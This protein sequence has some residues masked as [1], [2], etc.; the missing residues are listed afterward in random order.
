MTSKNLRENDCCFVDRTCILQLYSQ[1]H[2]CQHIPLSWHH[3]EDAIVMGIPQSQ[4]YAGQFSTSQPSH[5]RQ[6]TRMREGG[7]S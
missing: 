2:K 4:D 5:P 3:D 6:T 1:F 7:I